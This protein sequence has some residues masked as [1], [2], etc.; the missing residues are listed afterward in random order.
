[1]GQPTK[2]TKAIFAG[3]VTAAGQVAT[4]FADGAATV[5]EWAIGAGAVI[6]AVGVV[7]GVTNKPAT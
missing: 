5:A 6:A 3:L 4:I 1:M 2:P 7:Y